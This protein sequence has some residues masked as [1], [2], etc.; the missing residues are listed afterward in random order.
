MSELFFFH[1][2]G[3]LFSN[4]SSL[5]R[6]Y[7]NMPTNGNTIPSNIFK[8]RFYQPEFYKTARDFK[9]QFDNRNDRNDNN[10]NN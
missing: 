5:S 6:G 10:N 2:N 9:T 4:I 8:D 7:E 3:I 1:K